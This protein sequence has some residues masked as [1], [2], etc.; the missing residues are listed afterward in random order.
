MYTAANICKMIEFLIDN[1][2]VQF[3]ECL[4]R[5]A[6]ETLVGTNCIPLVVDHFPHSYENK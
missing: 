6:I 4:F 2:F 1:N 3:G 5:Q